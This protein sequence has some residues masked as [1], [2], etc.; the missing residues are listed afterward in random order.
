MK[1]LAHLF[2]IAAG[3][4]LAGCQH[5]AG[6]QDSGAV[7]VD[8]QN[9]DNFRDV[10]DSLGGPTDE[11]AL[12]ALR[13]FLQENAPSYL[14][15]GQKLHVTFTDIDLAGDFPV[16]GGGRYDRV[17]VIR[18]VYIPRQEFTFQVTDDAG[19]LVKEGKRTLTDLNFQANSLRIGSD[20]PYFYDKILL[21]DWLRKEF[22]DTAAARTR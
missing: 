18:S 17:R 7:T 19:H 22:K 10:R 12:A 4:G 9:P 5:P 16:S 13:T 6:R 15:S 11:S 2:L 1:T 3:L 20:Q 14:A 21:E 8:F